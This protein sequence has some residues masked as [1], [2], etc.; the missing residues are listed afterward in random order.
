MVFGTLVLLLVFWSSFD[1]DDN[2]YQAE[3]V[4]YCLIDEV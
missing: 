3:D 2:H 1:C 4:G